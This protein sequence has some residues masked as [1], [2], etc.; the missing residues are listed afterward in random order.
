VLSQLMSGKLKS[1][2]TIKFG[3]FAALVTFCMD[4]S[5]SIRSST[6]L[7]GGGKKRRC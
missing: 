4:Q 1:P 7:L 5:S 2:A 3:I 6:P